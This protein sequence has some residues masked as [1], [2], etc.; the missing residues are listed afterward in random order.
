MPA[1][2]CLEYPRRTAYQVAQLNASPGRLRRCLWTA[3]A[4]VPPLIAQL[5]SYG[6]SE[7][8]SQPSAS[9]F[10]ISAQERPAERSHHGILHRALEL[11]SRYATSEV[12][13]EMSP[14]VTREVPDHGNGRAVS[15]G[16]T[17]R[18]L[19]GCC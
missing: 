11:R 7:H 2:L 9:L 12:G 1:N 6:V 5:P 17:R 8:G 13:P 19:L 16:C 18:M 3:P 4:R 15:R 10:V 14:T